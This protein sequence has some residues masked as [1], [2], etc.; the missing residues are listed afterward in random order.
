MLGVEEIFGRFVEWFD[1]FKLGHGSYLLGVGYFLNGSSNPL[2]SIPEVEILYM[3]S[4]GRWNRGQ[5]V[6]NKERANLF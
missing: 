2:L 1:R 4:P 5:F 6:S 3:L